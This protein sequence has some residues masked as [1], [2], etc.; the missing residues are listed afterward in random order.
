M[1]K[2]CKECPWIRENKMSLDFRKSV[3]KMKE[4]KRDNHACHMITKDIWG[5]DKDISEKN[6]C[7]GRKNFINK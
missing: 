2:E 4:I 5:Y 6:V 7:I 3:N 1:R